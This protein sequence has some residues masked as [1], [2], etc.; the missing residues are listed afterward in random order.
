MGWCGVA[1][2]WTQ[3]SLCSPAVG[4]GW[5]AERVESAAYVLENIELENS[6][7]CLDMNAISPKNHQLFGAL[8]KA[9]LPLSVYRAAHVISD[10]IS[11]FKSEL[12][13]FLRDLHSL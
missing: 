4:G 12:S 5:E 1:S 10:D 6:N 9:S 2:W 11:S 8:T 13:G 7:V 3:W